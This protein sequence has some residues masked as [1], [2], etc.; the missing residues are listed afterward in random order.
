LQVDLVTRHGEDEQLQVEFSVPIPSLL[1]LALD[2]AI[3]SLFS[4]GFPLLIRIFSR[5]TCLSLILDDHDSKHNDNLFTKLS[6]QKLWCLMR[7]Y[8]GLSSPGSSNLEQIFVVSL[9]EIDTLN[10]AKMSHGVRNTR[11]RSASNY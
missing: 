2:F 3:Q 7:Y 1:S 4:Q 11:F 9:A 5:L 8:A 10:T 6:P